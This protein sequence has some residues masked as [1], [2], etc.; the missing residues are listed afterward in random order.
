VGQAGRCAA[1]EEAARDSSRGEAARRTG[2][3]S[4]CTIAGVSV[5]IFIAGVAGLAVAAYGFGA[6][7][8]D[9]WRRR[10][11]V[12]IVV[13]ALLTVGIVYLLINFGDRIVR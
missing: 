10:Q 9:A 3:R 8:V 2:R 4:P 12:D 11:Y 6:L 13:V 5:I 7:A 1:G